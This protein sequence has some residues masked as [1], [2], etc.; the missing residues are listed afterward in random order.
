MCLDEYVI[1]E[2]EEGKVSL[3]KRRRNGRGPESGRGR[4]MK[5]YRA[6]NN[7]LCQWLFGLHS[8]ALTHTLEERQEYCDLLAE[9][10]DTTSICRRMMGVGTRLETV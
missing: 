1:F 7:H 3:D 9:A 10:A 6:C 5:A 8:C 4:V 2:T